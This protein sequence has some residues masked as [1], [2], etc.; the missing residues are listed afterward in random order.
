MST[1]LRIRQATEA[2]ADAIRDINKR[3]WPGYT[4]HELLERRHGMLNGRPW[5]EHI[6]SAV[7]ANMRGRNVTTF[8]AER[9]G[10]VIG[11]ATAQIAKDKPSDTGTV[12][13]NAVDPDHRGRGVGTALIRHVVAFLEEKG[14]RVL[15]VVT[16][17]IDEP[18][19]RI[20]ER[21]GFK[22]LTRLVYYSMDCERP[23]ES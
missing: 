13:Y 21:L 2:D 5:A 18:V 22:E 14:A 19:R 1:E 3:A 10:R 6:A 20:Y 7:A 11:Y 4:T 17:E 12:G 15:T 9:E 8:V 23:R 16:L